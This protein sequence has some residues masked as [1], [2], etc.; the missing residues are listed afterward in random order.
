MSWFA[1]LK[2]STK[3]NIILSL[4]LVFIFL[5]A[6]FFVYHRERALI[7]RIAVDN[8]RSIAR[9]IIETRD[10]ISSVVKGE[11]NENYNLVPQVVATNV[12]KRL[13]KGSNYYVRQVSL[14]YRNPDNRPDPYEEEMLKLFASKKSTETYRIVRTGKE[15]SFRYMLSMVAEKSCLECH[16]RYE[17]APPFVRARFPKGHF[18]Y[19]YKVG[20]VIG[21]VSVS[22]PLADLYRE[23]GT[24]F[25]LD[26]A[27]RG[28]T[29]CLIILVMGFLV[30]R[31]IIDPLRKVSASI[32]HVTATG[33]FGDRIPQRSRDEIGELVA[34]FN[35]MMEEL[36]LKTRQRMESEDR[37]RNVLEMAQSA[38]VTFLADG[39]LIIANRRAEE[40]FGLPKGE[41]LGATIYTFLADSDGVRDGIAAYLRD[42]TGGVVGETTSRKIRDVR[43]GI[44]EVEM[45]LSVS[46]SDHNPLFTAILREHNQHTAY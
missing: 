22:I 40:L 26:L 9:Q 44:T 1:N 15:R 29:F 24:N 17:D 16:G 35:G 36:D 7:D 8:A 30:R 45:A 6:A 27:T 41:L 25:R 31:T 37:Y 38:I 19:N 20:E 18:S 14:R 13:T 42:G 5:A 33:S 43:G 21:A 12:A 39:K 4:L 11:P 10:Y 28:L 3:F 2:I 46:R 23:A 32:T 34:A